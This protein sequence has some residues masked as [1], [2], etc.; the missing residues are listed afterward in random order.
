MVDVST[1]PGVNIVDFSV[2]H[3]SG[4]TL[5]PQSRISFDHIPNYPDKLRAVEHTKWSHTAVVTGDIVC[6]FGV[7]E[8]WPGLGEAWML[9]SDKVKR[10]PI[11][12]T[13]GA[14][15]YFDAAARD[16]QLRRLQITT[17]VNDELAVRWA[18]RLN[19]TQEGLLRRYGPDGSD[20]FMHSRMY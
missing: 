2:R 17:N 19:F 13:R 15:R 20:H 6:C 4:M 7:I 10:Y 5:R 14:R 1:H 8:L 3:L 11:S 9:T 12:L 16:L 18:N